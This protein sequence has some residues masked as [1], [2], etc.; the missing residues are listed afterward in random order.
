MQNYI[1]QLDSKKQPLDMVHPAKAR[2][3]Q[4]KGKAATFRMFP[5]TII[6][7]IS[8]E[9]LNTKSY[10]LKIDPGATWTGFAIQCGEEIIFRMELKH[11]GEYIKKSLEQ[12]AGFR[13]GRRS[14]N[15]RYRKKRFNRTK[16]EGWLPPSLRHR[17]QTIETWIKKFL[18]FCPINS[19][20]IEQVR[21]DLQKLENPEISGI[22][23]QQ[24]EL[25]GYEV[26][27]YL[28]E[29][30]GRQCVYCSEQD[31]PLQIEHIKPKSKGGSN[32]IGNLTL[33]CAECNQLK[34]NQDVKDFLS[35]KPDLLKRLLSNAPKPLAS[36]A[37]C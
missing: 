4:G 32:R 17:L 37:C 16:P 13:R 30:W 12:R 6:R 29:K 23:Y 20:E 36:E 34:G 5:Y 21:F 18:K 33:A 2:K 19:I 25:E 11:R 24:G 9:S 14:R 22:Q 31:V 35:G 27:E 3:L 8:L 15:I 7:N 26:R 10:T 28:L 1:F